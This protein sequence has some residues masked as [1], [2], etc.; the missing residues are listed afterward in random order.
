MCICWFNVPLNRGYGRYEA[1]N[2]FTVYGSVSV[3]GG[4][5]LRGVKLLCDNASS[6]ILSEGQVALLLLLA[7]IH[8]ILL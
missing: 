4:A 2:F 7:N 6:L 8:F 3:S 1:D 5:V